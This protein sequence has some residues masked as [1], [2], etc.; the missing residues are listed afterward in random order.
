MLYQ[1]KCI[2]GMNNLVYEQRLMALKL[3][4]LEY[5]R[6]RGDMIE[7]FKKLY[8]LGYYDHETLFLV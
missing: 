1:M 6:A 5:S 8:M 3:P 2:T 7:T 4:R